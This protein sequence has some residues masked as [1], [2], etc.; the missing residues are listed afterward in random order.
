MTDDLVPRL[1][2]LSP[3][4]GSYLNEADWKQPDW[5]WV[6]YRNNY[7]ALESIKRKYDPDHIFYARTAVGS[8]HW[9]QRDDGRLCLA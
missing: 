9:V 8:D 1:T 2:A 3:E 5:Q 6:F 7:P 4:S